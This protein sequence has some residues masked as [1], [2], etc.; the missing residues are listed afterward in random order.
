LGQGWG[1]T[2][3]SM[4]G[5]SALAHYLRV[6]KR[7]AWIILL[8]TVAT[9]AAA[10]FASAR[11]QSLYQSTA[12]VFLSFQNLAATLSNVQL[13][14]IDPVREA[15]TQADLARTPVVAERALRRAGLGGRDPGYLLDASSVS[16]V[17]NVNLLKFS[18]TNPDPELAARLATAYARAYTKYRRNLDTAAIVSA[19]K[20]LSERLGEFT[21]RQRQSSAYTNLVEKQQELLT[22]ERLQSS[23]ALLV[24]EASGAVQVQPHPVRNSILG[25]LLGLVVGIGF[26][27]LADALNTRVRSVKEIQEQLDL[28]LL[29]RLPEPPRKLRSNDQLIMLADPESDRAEAFRILATNIDF[30][31]LDRAAKSIMISSAGRAEGKST[32]A[33]N[34]AV[35]FAR[36]GR[37]VI[38]VDQDL[39][40][41][42]LDRFFG[43]QDRPGLTHVMLGRLPLED[44][45]VPIPVIDSDSRAPSGNGTIGGVLQ[46][47]PAGA[48]PPN[49]SEFARS[50]VLAEILRRL[51]EL[52]DIVIVDAPPLLGLSD[53]VA[54]TAS[55]D[56]LIVVTKLST[57]RRPVLAE[58][59]RV[60]ETTP[61]VKLGV[62]VTG[63]PVDQSY[64]YGYGY[65]FGYGSARKARAKQEQWI[66]P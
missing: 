54:L 16:A 45:L 28:P 40:L 31:N 25:G 7:G 39:R 22:L 64:G 48:L 38:V 29:G 49:P 58:L 35:T 34:L 41:P 24:R 36:A 30:V 2:D 13:P 42:S 46:A 53:S 47:L 56:A 60:L 18:V 21:P 11:Q 63:V 5:A 51:E 52:A 26:A 4:G 50:P 15:A 33:A 66:G 3:E 61:V 37:R 6:L 27:F 62:A 20:E 59:H 10:A 14:S 44:A 55:V 1:V 17:P 12:D 32:T 65:A 8:C 9:V 23:N 19:R 43:I 57:A